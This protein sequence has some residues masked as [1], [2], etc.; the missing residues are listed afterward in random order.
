MPGSDAAEIREVARER[1]WVFGLLIAPCGI[2]A[3]GVIQGGVL[4][5]VL[6]QQGI[7]IG[8]ISDMVTV[9]A[10]PTMLY[11]LWS[12]ITDFF[13]RRRTWLMAGGL[14]AAALIAWAL[15]QPHLSSRSVLVCI[16]VS[17]C[18]AQLV[19]SSCG[20][21]MGALRSE[22]AKRVSSSFYQAGSMGFGAVSVSLLIWIYNHSPALL[23]PVAGAI[24]G[25]PALFALL[26]PEQP[27]L[28]HSSVAETC[29]Q[30]RREA[31]QTFGRWEAIPYLLVM[32]FPLATGAAI[33]LLPGV[34]QDYGVSGDQVA[35]MNGLLG[36]L[37]T[38]AGSLLAS[39][40]PVFASASVTYLLL[41]IFNSLTVG[42]LW[43]APPTPATYFTGMTLYIFS[44]GICYALFTGVILEFLGD[45]GKSGS[46]RYSIINSLGNVPVLYMMKLDGMGASRFGP[47]ALA[48][49][50]AVLGLLGASSLL[51]YFL[52]RGPRSRPAA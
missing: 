37:L 35:W 9:L 7:A 49:T 19:V 25:I 52:L 29:A 47:R 40:I 12:P 1:P 43:L 10:L 11:F 34:A 30:L 41:A 28:S 6:R 15:S 36:T 38:V 22:R 26:A 17:A 13:V 18:A 2:V 51:A 27:F 46:G 8:S 50:E 31:V 39:L 24:V 16:F 4:S 21:M 14:S 33:G 44:V 20:G 3:N 32:L 42:V 48:G 45:S 23:G 5:Y